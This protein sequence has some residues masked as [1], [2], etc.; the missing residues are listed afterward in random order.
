MDSPQLTN[1]H[2]QIDLLDKPEV[3]EYLAGLRRRRQAAYRCQPL[4]GGYRDPW[5][6]A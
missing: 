4:D 6:G 3:Q 1:P 5:T 2:R